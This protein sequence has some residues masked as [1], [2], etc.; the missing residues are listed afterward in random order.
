MKF[1]E[2]GGY[3]YSPADCHWKRV[4]LLAILLVLTANVRFVQAQGDPRKLAEGFKT[5]PYASG[6]NLPTSLTYD[7]DGAIYVTELNGGENDNVGRIVRIEKP[8]ATPQVLLEKLPKPTGLAFAGDLYYVMVRNQVL[9]GEVKDGKLSEPRPVFT[10][11]IPFNGRSLGLIALG[12]DGLLYFQSTGTE[13]A[14]RDSGFIYSLKPGTTERKIVARGLKNAY[15]FA[16]NPVTDTM[17]TT[18][19][20]DANI[21]GVGAPPEELNIVKRGGNYGWPQC[22]ADQREDAGW[23]GNR[24]ICADTDMPLAMFPPQSTPTAIAWYDGA[25]IVALF[26]GN[27]P[28]LVRVDPNSGKWEDFSTL[29]KFPIGLL[30]EKDQSGNLLVLDYADGTITR[31]VKE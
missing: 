2:M 24:N 5:E 31:I 13:L 28:R 30:N 10:E 29:S 27:P 17:Y 7:A 22:Y 4:V 18:E 6:L 21:R 8:G 23:G 14:W 1:Q 26:N 16:W 19:I 11:T 9:V 15:A 12:P 25:L 3:V 20:G